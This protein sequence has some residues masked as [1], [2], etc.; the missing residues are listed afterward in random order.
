[1]LVASYNTRCLVVSGDGL[2][3]LTVF[4]MFYLCRRGIHGMFPLHLAVLYGF[5]DCCR[6]LLSSGLFNEYM[7]SALPN[8]LP[9]V[10]GYSL[11]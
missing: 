8:A 9:S 5:S 4:V 11:T 7:H 2:V 1:M 3:I 10:F 6:K